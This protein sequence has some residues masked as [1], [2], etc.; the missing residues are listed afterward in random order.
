MAAE[1]MPS[2]LRLSRDGRRRGRGSWGDARWDHRSAIRPS[3]RPATGA[4]IRRLGH[5]CLPDQL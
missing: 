5:G 2:D 4:T 3:S 1:T